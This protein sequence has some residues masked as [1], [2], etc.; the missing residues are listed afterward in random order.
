MTY[1]DELITAAERFV[2]I[3]HEVEKAD[4]IFVPGGRSMAPAEMAAMLYAKGLAPLILPSG[5]ESKVDSS[6]R[7][8][9]P[10][11]WAAMYER[12]LQL[13]VPAHSILKENQATYTYQNALF[14][15]QVLE[16]QGICISRAILVCKPVHSHRCYHYYGS[17][18]TQADI[19]V[20]HCKDEVTQANWARSEK[21][22]RSVFDEI[23]R[24]G[25][26]QGELL[27]PFV[28]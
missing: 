5:F 26:Y 9:Y 4:V 17:C 10:S 27:M 16:Q 13:G 21:G 3:S 1:P 2:F 12:L 18:F 19:R 14:S 23:V 24:I 6:T 20:C 25:K 22:I 8:S 15:R 11:E 7:G 28:E